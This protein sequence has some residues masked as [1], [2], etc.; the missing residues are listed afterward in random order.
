[1]IKTNIGRFLL[2]I[3][4]QRG[5]PLSLCKLWDTFNAI[6]YQVFIPFQN[7]PWL[8]YRLWKSKPWLFLAAH[9]E[10]SF[11]RDTRI[12]WIYEPIHRSDKQA[13]II[14]IVYIKQCLIKGQPHSSLT[15]C[16]CHSR[17]KK[18]KAFFL[19]AT[20]QET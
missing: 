15:T 3:Y 12:K 11:T 10:M 8:F 13:E 4:S 2:Y 16:L 5:S 7:P 17:K 14:F 9:G 20:L 19:K 6:F 18:K 1:M